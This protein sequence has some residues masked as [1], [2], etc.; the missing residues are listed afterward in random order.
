M[1]VNQITG[2]Y[3]ISF[4]VLREIKEICKSIPSMDVIIERRFTKGG[5]E[6][7][8]HKKKYE[9][10]VIHTARRT[11]ATLLV[12]SGLQ[13]HQVMKITGHKKITTLQKYSKS[14][15]DLQKMIEVGR[16]IERG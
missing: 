10:V 8:Q 14:D 13:Y 3:W 2:N 12:N 16:L 4:G 11:L 9:M 15:I 1:P 7:R 5:M 6:V